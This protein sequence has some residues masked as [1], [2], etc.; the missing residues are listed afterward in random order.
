MPSITQLVDAKRTVMVPFA[1]TALTVSYRPGV[2][3]PRLQKAIAQAQRDQDLD[4]GL[5]WPMAE[6]LA[7]WDLTDDDGSV[8]ATTPDALAD[9]PASVLLTVLAAIGEDMAPNPSSA[10]RSSN[11]SSPTAS[12]APVLNGTRS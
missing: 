6:L 9:V 10:E 8:I 1:D 12:S 11:G 5:L 2:V 4:A 7:A 3:T